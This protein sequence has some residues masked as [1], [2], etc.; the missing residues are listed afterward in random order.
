MLYYWQPASFR[1]VPFFIDTFEAS[2]GRRGPDHEFPGKDEGYPEDTGGKIRSHTINAYVARTTS[3]P[4]YAS[5]RD[6][7]IAAASQYGPGDLIHPVWGTIRIQILEWSVSESKDALGL[8]PIVL[9]FVE[10]SEATYPTATKAAS[11]GMTTAA[12]SAHAAA[13][14]G[15]AA[16]FSVAGKSDFLRD[17]AAAD[18]GKA[19]DMFSRIASSNGVPVDVQ[20]LAGTLG[21][22]IREATRE[23]DGETVAHALAAIPQA[24]TAWYEAPFANRRNQDGTYRG[25]SNFRGGGPLPATAATSLFRALDFTLGIGVPAE[26]AARRQ[27]AANAEAVAHLTRLSSAIEAA[28]VAPFIDWMTIQEAEAARDRIA[29]T[30]DL[31]AEETG[32]DE[33]FNALTDMRVLVSRT[34]PPENSQLPY[35]M[36]Y[37]PLVTQPTL[38]L[39]FRLYGASS[40]ADEISLIN[41]IRHPGFVPGME[42]LQV[43]SDVV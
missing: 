13:A 31:A 4:D 41:R 6:A 36:E 25:T 9:S 10:A 38:A 5:R 8:A 37:A 30:L 39:A 29:E 14:R 28:R 21:N 11:S 34:V 3:D 16:V 19:S 2:G 24:F 12:A 22:A 17:S 35:L 32:S 18:A 7:L 43:I 20:A 40:R 15:F 42:L 33:L 26:T 27:Q 23:N 1:G